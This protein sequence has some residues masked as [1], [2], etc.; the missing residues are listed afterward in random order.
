MKYC[1]LDIAMNFPGYCVMQR[2]LQTKPLA[3]QAC[4][5]DSLT[6]RFGC[7]VEQARKSQG[8]T[9]AA[10][11]QA[12]HIRTSSLYNIEHCLTCARLDTVEKL[13]DALSMQ[14]YELLR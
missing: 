6:E 5:C 1:E 7:N 8:F 3:D 11:C 4:F 9:R 12:A 10:L 13:A 2:T 14:P